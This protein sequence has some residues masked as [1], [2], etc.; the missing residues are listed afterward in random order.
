LTFDADRNPKAQP[1]QPMRRRSPVAVTAVAVGIVVIATIALANIWTELQW[2]RQVGFID[3]YRIQWLARL[4]IFLV[5]GLIAGG[6]VWL[7]LWVARRA[8]PERG[9]RPALDQ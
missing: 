5:F 3:V 8:R 1:P 6:T 7:T 9:G 4:A 2:Y